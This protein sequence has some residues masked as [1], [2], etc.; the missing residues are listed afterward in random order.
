MFLVLLQVARLGE[1]AAAL[2]AAEG[3]AARVGAAV[4]GQAARAQERLAAQAAEKFLLSGLWFWPIQ[5]LMN[6]SGRN[7]SNVRAE[8]RE[9]RPACQNL[10]LKLPTLQ[11][12]SDRPG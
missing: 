9:R 3:L 10:Q 1:G 6:V 5:L 11:A 2:V 4:H 12:R 7:K 8:L